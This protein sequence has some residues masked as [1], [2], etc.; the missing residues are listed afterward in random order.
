VE[1]N[2]AF[3][4]GPPTPSDRRFCSESEM[5]RA[6]EQSLAKERPVSPYHIALSL[7][8]V[9]ER[10]LRRKFPHL[11]HTIQEKI[12]TQKA[13]RAAAM[14]RILVAALNE[15]PPPT[16]S[17]MCSRVR[18][19]RPVILRKR[20]ARLCDRLLERRR[21]FRVR[22]IET[23]RKELH[24]LS[25]MSPA[26][27]LEQACKRV[28]LTRQRLVSLCPEESAALVLRYKQSR[29]E[30]TLRHTQDIERSVREIVER[31]HQKGKYP[32]FK[33]V[34]AL[35]GKSARNWRAVTAAIRAA[36]RDS[37]AAPSDPR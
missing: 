1:P 3:A 7:G 32:S 6:L 12:A 4:G 16:L 37:N 2:L 36:K 15:D 35:L 5:K 21:E 17:E 14:E 26:L 8:F 29:H 20:F 27:S 18:C 13:M 22:H 31:L 25:L 24:R 19:C 10:V 30:S 23:L 33:R 11:C 28:G 9:D 34:R